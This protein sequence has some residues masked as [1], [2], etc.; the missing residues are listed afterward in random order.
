M[1]EETNKEVTSNEPTIEKP[2]MMWEEL[3]LMFEETR[4]ELIKQQMLVSETIKHVSALMEQDPKLCAAMH[5]L[6]KC[7]TDIAIK[8]KQNA[9]YHMK[10]DENTNSIVEYKQGVID[11]DD[12]DSTLAFTQIMT[13]YINAQEQIT[14]IVSTGFLEVF[15][16]IKANDDT[17]LSNEDLAKIP[18]AYEEGQKEI[19]E[20]MKGALQD[21]EQSTTSSTTTDEESDESDGK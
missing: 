21:A 16:L 17:L 1:S 11:E 3:K 15:T 13:N 19:L 20:T 9:T 10:I 18:A 5:G 7:F 8:L 4:N 12:V 14:H 2:Q 6:I